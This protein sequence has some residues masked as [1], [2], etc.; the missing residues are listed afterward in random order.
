MAALASAQEALLEPSLDEG[1][2]ERSSLSPARLYRAGAVTFVSAALLCLWQLAS[3]DQSALRG[4]EN[5]ATTTELADWTRKDG[6][7]L[8]KTKKFPKGKRWVWNNPNFPIVPWSRLRIQPPHA[9]PFV[10]ITLHGDGARHDV[11]PI[12]GVNQVLRYDLRD[13]SKDPFPVLNLSS[14]PDPPRMLRGMT[15][16]P[17]G[18]LLVAQGHK[19]DS[20][21]LQYGPCGPSGARQF[22]REFRSPDMVHPYDIAQTGN[23]E[24]CASTQDSKTL[25]CFN[26]SAATGSLW[27]EQTFVSYRKHANYRGLAAF[28][29]CL[30][31]AEMKHNEIHRLCRRNGKDSNDVVIKIKHPIGLAVDQL[32]GRL[33][34]GSK[35]KHHSEVAVFDLLSPIPLFRLGRLHHPGMKHPTG[36]ALGDNTVLVG[37]QDKIG[38]L[39]EFEAS[40]GTFKRELNTTR[41]PDKV[42]Q[43]LFSPC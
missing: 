39:I 31:A 21:I 6:F 27:M 20:A 16:L 33:Y 5:P 8:S 12:K 29:G 9:Q 13:P 30:Y 41:F 37:D 42:E 15:I 38:H 14:S 24:F 11:L 36:I 17:D 35:Q 4:S 26:A 22:V 3:S 25:V 32:N 19:Y 1:N 28:D 23:G 10:Y 7:S 43:I 34:V 18:S 40:T 2:S